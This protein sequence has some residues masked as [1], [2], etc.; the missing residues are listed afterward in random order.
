M[1]AIA[2]RNVSST[3]LESGNALGAFLQTTAPGLEKILDPWVEDVYPVVGL[4]LSTS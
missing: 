1:T 3:D 2:D 4:G